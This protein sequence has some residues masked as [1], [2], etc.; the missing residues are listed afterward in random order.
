M[1]YR[2]VQLIEGEFIVSDV[3]QEN[4]A[5]WCAVRGFV[6]TGVNRNPRQRAE[7][8][9]HPKIDCLA[10]PMWGGEGIIRY[11]DDAPCDALS[12]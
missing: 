4:L 12:T 5:T 8:Q 10:G 6:I 2:I 11:E 7:L 3:S 9:G 1:K